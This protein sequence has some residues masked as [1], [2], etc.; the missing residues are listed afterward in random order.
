MNW[1]KTAK[2]VDMNTTDNRTFLTC[3]RCRR[4]ATSASGVPG[5]KYQWKFYNQMNADE[6]KEVDRAQVDF[7]TGSIDFRDELCSYCKKKLAKGKI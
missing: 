2:L 6:R 5:E 1:Y 3:F 4:W 7:M